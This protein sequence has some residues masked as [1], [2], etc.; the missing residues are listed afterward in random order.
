[1]PRST[2]KQFNLEIDDSINEIVDEGA[3]NSYI[4]LRKLRWNEDAPFKLDIRRWYINSN[5]EE[6]AGKGLSFITDEGPHNLTE[7]LTRNG[8]GRTDVI[9]DNIKNRQDFLYEAK[10]VLDELGSEHGKL[11]AVEPSNPFTDNGSDAVFYDP[12]EMLMGSIE[13]E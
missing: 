9:L 4:A 5:G 1:M 2:M 11:I 3:G 10:R 8:F 12:K 13:E 7:I 6:I